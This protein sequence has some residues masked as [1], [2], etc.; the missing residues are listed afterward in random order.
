M[1]DLHF[2]VQNRLKSFYWHVSEG[3]GRQQHKKARCAQLEALC[4]LMNGEYHC[5]KGTVN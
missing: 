1:A 2:Q 4:M 5:A 3:S